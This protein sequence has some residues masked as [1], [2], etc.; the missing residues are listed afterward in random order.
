MTTKTSQKELDAVTVEVVRNGLLAITEEMKTNLMRTAYNLIIY[1]A[2]DFTVGLFTVTGETISIGLGLPM[3]IRG[4]AET[5]KAKLRHFGL[6]GIHP[7][8]ILVTNDAYT[9][10]SHLNHF[11]F[12]QPIFH[13]GEIIAF[14]CCMAHWLDVGGTLG[15]VT[16]D[17]FSEGIQIPIV[18]YQKAGV[19]NQDLVDIIAMNV[20]LP[21]RALGDL[22]A[23][24]TAVTTGERRFRE[25]VGRYG[26]DAVLGSV[27]KIMDQSETIARANT[28]SIP[29]GV[30]EAESYMDDDGVEIGKRIPIKV[31]VEKR[32]DEMTIDLSDVSRQVRGFYNSGF[33]TG[34]ACAQV[35][36]KC[37]T[38]P[39]DYPV[40][41]GS[42]RPLKVIMPMGRVI[43]AERPF[44]MRVW[45]TFPMTV[46]DTIFKALANAIP[47]RVVAG[48]HADLV[49][50]N[51]HGI[52]P[53]DGKLFIVG[54]GPLGGGW[55][56]KK[57]E[58][59]VSATVCMNDGDTHNSPTEQLESKYP[60][61]V[62]RYAL[63]QDSAGAGHHRGG[64]GAEMVVQALSPF[65]VTTRID[66]MHC[67]PWGLHGGKEA[68]GNGIGIRRN[69]E[70][71]AE[72]PNAKIFGVR[73]RRGDAYLMQS[74]GGGGFGDPLNRDPALVAHD[75]REGY[76]S[77]GAARED[78]G[79]VVNEEGVLDSAATERLRKTRSN[80]GGAEFE[81]IAG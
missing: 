20:R 62:E 40:N 65:S 9:T 72:L 6:D 23:Q 47:D 75:V 16:T 10:G 59:G 45:M 25:L 38:T 52:S 77:V 34:I 76:I 73:L 57:S 5:V 49:F 1:E 81:I 8:D 43:S 26:K 11:T 3:F 30:Y 67:K 44:P 28:R 18:K 46:I 2:L 63:R 60:V 54:I 36:F 56:A 55:G 58:D 31:R 13:E 33:T 69:S 41:D 4:M 7:G 17:I 78:Y 12:T 68:A 24:I 51:I 22:R 14:S 80:G 79:V 19:V 32:G 50:P 15:Q 21:E 70:W 37:L 35:A 64:L 71:E 66:R 27:A 74:G 48:H 39:T 29:D 53:H 61:L 42:F